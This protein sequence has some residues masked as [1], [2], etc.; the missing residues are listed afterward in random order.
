[1]KA[2]IFDGQLK[3]DT[4]FP[5]PQPPAGWAR[6][7]VLKAGICR[8]DLE[9]TKGYMGFKGVLGHEFV[10]VVDACDDAQWAGKR[11]AGEINASCGRCDWC[12]RGLGRHCPN[13]TVLGILNH[14][15]C[16]AEYCIL[17]VANLHPIPDGMSDDTA[18]FTEPVSAAFE[19][20]EQ[21]PLTGKESCIVLGDGKL[22]I[23]CAW[24]L[25]TTGAD[26]TLVGRH[27]AKLERAKWNSLRT[28]RDADSLK[29]AD[30]VVDATGSEAGFMQAISLCKPRGTLVLK[31]TVAA[32]AQI[33]LAP[34]VINEITIVGSRC[35]LFSRGLA[36]MAR[37]GFPLDRLIDG[38]YPLDDALAA[39]A[40]AS[41]RGVLKILLDIA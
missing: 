33:N 24:A 11:V 14:D 31:S 30:I 37:H 15:G 35:G 9:L 25:C 16:M 41:E 2:L 21:I 6:I 17:P 40:R 28:T 36:E 22:G 18:V 3:M 10:G 4:D 1:M 26:V 19:I 38:R 7:R 5:L 29:P 12:A 8:T 34:V 27:D 39:F 20:H 23:L 32:S 13:R